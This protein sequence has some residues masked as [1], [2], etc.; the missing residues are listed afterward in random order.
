M[1]G[2]DSAMAVLKRE[3][4]EVNEVEEVVVDWRRTGEGRGVGLGEKV[5]D[6]YRAGLVS[7]SWY[8]R[9]VKL[10]QSVRDGRTTW[11]VEKIGKVD[12]ATYKV[13]TTSPV[14]CQLSVRNLPS[15]S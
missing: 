4:V 14:R 7:R 15:S 9:R 10:P 1:P 8:V 3:K 13:L 2:P 12:H 5:R 11:V 6:M